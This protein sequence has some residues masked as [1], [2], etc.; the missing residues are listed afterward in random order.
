MHKHGAKRI[1]QKQNS[2]TSNQNVVAILATLMSSIVA[3]A[4][5]A[6]SSYATYLSNENSLDLEKCSKIEER[7]EAFVAEFNV[8]S[9]LRNRIWVLHASHEISKAK[10]TWNEIQKLTK[11]FHDVENRMNVHEY[12]A[13]SMIDRSKYRTEIIKAEAF[14]LAEP[15]SDHFKRRTDKITSKMIKTQVYLGQELYKCYN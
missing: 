1:R 6:G 7:A 13:K 4:V 12:I 11:Q 8:Y 9:E 14:D 5:V 2:H 10:Q 15:Y 3:V